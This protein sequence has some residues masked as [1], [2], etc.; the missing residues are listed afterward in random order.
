[1]NTQ[2][3]RAALDQVILA[4]D[5]LNRGDTATAQVHATLAGALSSQAGATSTV[6]QPEPVA[7]GPS[8]GGPV[9]RGPRT[10]DTDSVVDEYLAEI[11]EFNIPD[12]APNPSEPDLRDDR[13]SPQ[14]RRDRNR[15]RRGGRPSRP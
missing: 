1:M 12:Q 2:L 7:G 15:E 8:R 10:G 3:T 9:I 5:A 6:V 14:E 11:D 13:I 4:I